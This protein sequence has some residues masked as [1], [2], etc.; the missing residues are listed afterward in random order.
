MRHFPAT[1]AQCHLYLV[2]LLEE[3]FHRPH[4]N[5][6]IMRVDIRAKLDFLDLDS[7]LLFACLGGL[8]LRLEFILSEIHD[9]TDRDFSIYRDFDEIETG[10]VGLCQRVTLANRPVIL[11]MLIDELDFASDNSFI[12][13]RPF[14]CGRASYRT[15]YVTSPIA[16]DVRER[17]VIPDPSARS[18]LRI[19]TADNKSSGFS[20]VAGA[21][22]TRHAAQALTFAS[23]C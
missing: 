8:L 15:A 3:L 16:V 4:L 10:F 5:V 11:S 9:L 20:R 1:E 19:K 18:K 22:P 17:G 7:L 12:N 2:A 23:Q 21:I 14:F 6:V 13:M